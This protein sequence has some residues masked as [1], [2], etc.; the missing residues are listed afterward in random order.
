MGDE[1]WPPV[2]QPN[3]TIRVAEGADVTNTPV[4][5]LAEAAKK[6]VGIDL[7]TSVDGKRMATVE[8]VTVEGN[9]RPDARLDE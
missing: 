5:N 1:L 3:L 9:V 4:A 2:A 8:K 7:T 6:G